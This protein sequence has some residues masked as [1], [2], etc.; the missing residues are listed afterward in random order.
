MAALLETMLI[1]RLSGGFRRGIKTMPERH[2]RAPRRKA[3]I[4]SSLVVSF[5]KE[6]LEKAPF[7]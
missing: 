5:K 7:L 4:K 2:W 3:K 1:M 6:H